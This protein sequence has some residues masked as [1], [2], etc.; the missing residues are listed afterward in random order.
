MI[1]KLAVEAPEV[2]IALAANNS[3]ITTETPAKVQLIKER[4]ALVRK[5]YG[6][7]EGAKAYLTSAFKDRYEA[8]IKRY[9][10]MSLQPI[11][12]VRKAIEEVVGIELTDKECETIGNTPG[13]VGAVT[14]GVDTGIISD[15]F[16]AIDKTPEMAYMKKRFI[17][18]AIWLGV[19]GTIDEVNNRIVAGL[20]AYTDEGTKAAKAAMME[21]GLTQFMIDKSQFEGAAIKGVWYSTV[22]DK[23]G[24]IVKDTYQFKDWDPYYFAGVDP[25][26]MQDI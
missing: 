8:A 5:A 1:E 11:E 23:D 12:V 15:F 4:I 25:F 9:A 7:W 21:F 6:T 19:K 20:N 2:A 13:F 26:T 24:N 18:R 14:A 22:K 17:D 3:T 16:T 10:S